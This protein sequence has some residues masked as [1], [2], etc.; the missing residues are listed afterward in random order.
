MAEYPNSYWDLADTKENKFME[1]KV[2]SNPSFAKEK[3]IEKSSGMESSSSL[4]LV[5]PHTG[6]VEWYNHE[7]GLRGEIKVTTFLAIRRLLLNSLNA[8]ETQMMDKQ[9]L[10]KEIFRSPW[11][12]DHMR[13]GR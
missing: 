13:Y 8:L 5:D 9:D 10:E 11:F 6:S 7:G 12:N 3:F 1:L 2:T 4:C